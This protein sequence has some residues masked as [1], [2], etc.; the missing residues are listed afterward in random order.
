[1][2][3]TSD[4]ASSGLDTLHH[5]HPPL[6]RPSATQHEPARPQRQGRN[7]CWVSVG[8]IPFPIPH[9][10][11]AESVWSPRR[12]TPERPLTTPGSLWWRTRAT[13]NW[14]LEGGRTPRQAIEVGAA[15]SLQPPIL[16]SDPGTQPS[17]GWMCRLAGTARSLAGVL[18]A[19][20][21]PVLWYFRGRGPD[22]ARFR[23]S[24]NRCA[25]LHPEPTHL[26]ALS[27]LP[28]TC[29]QGSHRA[30]GGPVPWSVCVASRPWPLSLQATDGVPMGGLPAGLPVEP[31]SVAATSTVDL[32][33]SS[34]NRLVHI[35]QGFPFFDTR[36]SPHGQTCQPGRVIPSFLFI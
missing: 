4:L 3:A 22:H 20:V 32:G 2:C 19:N 12:S 33:V 9:S 10:R 15:R 18:W 28:Q 17:L 23:I 6:R 36:S 7:S 14:Q 31:P 8:E 34:G 1:M 21:P 30:P 27:T 35:R 25:I 11:A 29:R 5:Y 13:G 24:A 26:M 16:D